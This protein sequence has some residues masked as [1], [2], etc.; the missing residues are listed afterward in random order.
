MKKL[1]EKKIGILKELKI[2]DL[3][4]DDCKAVIL[5]GGIPNSTTLRDDVNVIK[6]IKV[7]LACHIARYNSR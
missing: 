7:I 1:K 6:V 2:S 4:L 5:P 3:K